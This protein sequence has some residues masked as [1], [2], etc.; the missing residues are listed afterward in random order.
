[1][2]DAIP[3]V[4]VTRRTGETDTYVSAAYCDSEDVANET[5]ESFAVT[6]PGLV[7]TVETTE[8]F[9]KAQEA[10]A[11]SETTNAQDGN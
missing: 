7:H 9:T 3:H 8:D 4:V 1:M 6:S 11:T 10:L 5:R 2:S